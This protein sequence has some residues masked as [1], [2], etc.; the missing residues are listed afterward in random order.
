MKNKRLY[1]D[2]HPW[3]I[4]LLHLAACKSTCG[5]DRS[6]SLSASSVHVRLHVPKRWEAVVTCWFT[7]FEH[8]GFSWHSVHVEATR[9]QLHSRPEDKMANCASSLKNAWD[10]EGAWLTESTLWTSILDNIFYGQLFL[11]VIHSNGL[12]TVCSVILIFPHNQ[13]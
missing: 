4:T 3:M 7:V 6:V 10:T 11:L 8:L 12:T 9:V 1:V 2:R 5:S 13:T